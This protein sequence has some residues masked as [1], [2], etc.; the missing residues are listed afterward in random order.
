MKKLTIAAVLILLGALSYC[1]ENNSSELEKLANSIAKESKYYGLIIGINHYPEDALPDLENPITDAEKLYLTLTSSYNFEDENIMLLKDATRADIIKSL[2]QLTRDVTPDDNVLI[3]YAGHGTW[4]M[5]AKTY[6]W[7]PSDATINTKVNWL[8]DS[9]LSDYLKTINSKHTLLIA[10]AS[11]SGSI[12]KTR[13]AFPDSNPDL[14]SLYALPSRKAMTSCSLT[15]ASDNGIF[16]RYL[17][18]GLNDNEESCLSSEQLFSS[19]RMDVITNGDAI[20]QYGTIS[21][22]GDKGGDFIFYKSK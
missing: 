18:Q 4:D 20:P 19:F 21:D 1:Q 3:F 2:D 16:I 7:L 8:P 14:P 13:S 17:I 5:E 12:F 11:F 15:E 9:Q 6:Y 10:D 22:T